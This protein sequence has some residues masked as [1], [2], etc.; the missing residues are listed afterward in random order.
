MDPSVPI[1]ERI[2]LLLAQMTLDEK[3]NQLL[4][5]V[6][7]SLDQLMSTYG[8]TSVGAY[9]INATGNISALNELILIRGM[10]SKSILLKLL[11]CIFL[12][13]SLK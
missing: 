4:A 12:F 10:K 3:V 9:I 11:V 13:P 6:D 7:L 8:N 1:P 5:P 2:E